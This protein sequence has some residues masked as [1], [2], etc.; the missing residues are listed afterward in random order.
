MFRPRQF[1]RMFLGPVNG[2]LNGNGE[3]AMYHILSLCNSLRWTSLLAAI[4]V[5]V[6]SPWLI[7]ATQAAP[8]NPEKL[9]LWPD[10]APVGD[11]KF[12]AATASIT[13]HRPAP[14]KANGAAMVI[15]PGGGY[16]GL[17]AGAE[18]HGI[19]KWLNQHGI[20]GIV[21]EYRLPQGQGLR[22]AAGC[23]AGH[24]H[25]PLQ[26]Q[27][28]GASTPAASASS[29]SRRAGTWPPRRAPTSTAAIPRRPI[30][31]IA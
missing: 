17:V 19:A 27:S 6:V 22:A 12:E 29:A 11:G 9:S 24:P 26:R 31:S 28:S 3:T 8:P 7:V 13:V 4:A 18:G 23:A 30:P 10:Q 5:M 1:L 21:L 20:A 14:E 16:G 15:C 25:G 2:Y